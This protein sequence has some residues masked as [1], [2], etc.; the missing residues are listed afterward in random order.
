MRGHRSRGA[1]AAVIALLSGVMAATPAEAGTGGLAERH[2]LDAA[3]VTAARD[4]AEA[5]LAAAGEAWPRDAVPGS[6]LVTVTPGH[7]LATADS[8]A[9][10]VVR[11]EVPAGDEAEAA[12]ALRGRPG[13]VA[14]EPDLRLQLSLIPDDPA[15]PQQFAHR[16]ARAEQA[17]DVTTGDASLTVA[18]LDSGI[19]ADHP[20]LAGLVVD[21]VKAATGEILPGARD[22]DACRVGHGTWVAG[23]IG[24]LG[25]NGVDVAG[26]T[27][28]VSFV[29]VDVA[30][31]QACAAGGVTLSG[32]LAG[33]EYAAAQDVDLINLSLG[34]ISRSC[35]TALQTT[36]DAVRA[37]GIAVI[38]SSGNAGP[39]TTGVPGSCNGVIAVG[40]VGP[41]GGVAGYSSS[42]PHVDLVAPGGDDLDGDGTLTSAE[43]VLS[44]SYWSFGQ[45]TP[46]VIPLTGTSF[47]APY[48]TGV[49]ALMLSVDAGLTPQEIEGVLEAT[50]VD[51][52][53][54]GRDQEYGFGLVDAAAAVATV[55]AGGTLPAPAEDPGFP[56]GSPA[57][58]RPG[59]DVEVTRVAAGTGSTEP[60]TQAVAVSQTLFPDRQ[61]DS[62][63]AQYAVLARGDLFADGLAGS[64]LTLGAGP[65][66]FTGSSGAL[67]TETAAELQRVLPPGAGVLVLGGNQAVPP[68][69]D[70]D[71]R[72]LGYDPVRL[73]GTDRE[74]T[75]VAIAAAL[76]EMT[77]DLGFEMPA[78]ILASRS[79]WYDAI[80]AG[81]LAAGL[82]API[83]LTSSASLHPATA[84][85]LQG[86]DVATLYVV[87]G[88]VRIP[89][90]V[91]QQAAAVA[92][93][94]RTVL[95]AGEA[96]DGTAV[97]VAAELERLAG[98][99]G[100][101]PSSV[102]AINLTR[103]DGYA[104]ALSM[105]PVLAVLPTAYLP[106]LGEDGGV[107]TGV[108]V[109]HFRGA[110]L[111]ALIA[112][113]VDIISA[114][115]A[116]QLE[117]LLETP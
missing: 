5:R 41:T 50:A 14:V 70:D 51:Q 79:V 12:D 61:G 83:L 32:V 58:V 75:A 10:R 54:P 113:D 90:A 22:N 13:I 84:A 16:L 102:V 18:V 87:G 46:S 34:G 65:L 31:P 68:T 69:V 7:G 91:R 93:P 8:V 66:L 6:L 64:A 37:A 103:E 52:G 2:G 88:E 100:A 92:A 104:H 45:R 105:S 33:L 57:G 59:G 23:I 62:S 89:A 4:A 106:V 24:A 44:T 112:G 67:A 11:V 116:V 81:S 97:A 107:Y 39:G 55:A 20:D 42:N 111:P 19:V 108:T 72:A 9:E 85:T 74:G 82:P 99:L 60:I 17:W 94:A 30:D 27:H 28:G 78:A 49:A 15:Y 96:R 21:Q 80:T 115:S 48:V 3:G 56:V 117:R 109:E 101:S 26:V 40:A 29:D 43:G 1:A 71:L 53:A 38:A 73:F 36:L 47:S 86:L 114:T 35:P 110:A 63:R 95:L 76:G 98:E 25:N 77:T